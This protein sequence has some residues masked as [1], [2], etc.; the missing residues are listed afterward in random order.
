MIDLKVPKGGEV[1]AVALAA[2]GSR[3]A[4]QTHNDMQVCDP[5]GG[6]W[7]S[8]RGKRLNIS[9]GLAVDPA[10]RYAAWEDWDGSVVADLA[11][12][13]RTELARATDDEWVPDD[14]V[15]Q[16]LFS[17][18]GGELWAVSTRVR[19]WA[20]GSWLPLPPADLAV[21]PG[22]AGNVRLSA[23]G[24]AAAAW[25]TRWPDHGPETTVTFAAGAAP[26]T[27]RTDVDYSDNGAIDA[28]GRLF[29]ASTTSALTVWAVATGRGV[30]QLPAGRG[31]Y[32]TAVAFTPDGRTLLVGQGESVHSF[33]TATWAEGQA[34][35]WRAGR[36]TCLA[37]AA[38]GL[39]A[40]AG[41]KTG[42]VVVWDLG[43]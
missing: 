4:V 20:V 35:D 18:D 13:E 42:R 8:V 10:G 28:A 16:L 34:Y 30:F 21:P 12:G 36:V 19:R 15:R 38:G 32:I 29:A 27:V 11:S 14:K 31:G 43:G 40:A 37:I 3:L 5:A 1:S 24:T 6:A 2:D 25:T 22:P 33:D 7:R 39:T 26:V 9:Q 17:P 23:D 41:T